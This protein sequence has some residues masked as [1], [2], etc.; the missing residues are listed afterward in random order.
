MGNGTPIGRV[1][2][3]GSAHGGAHHWMVQRFTAF[4]NLALMAWFGIS[5][6]L[7]PN[8]DYITFVDWLAQPVSAT[9]LSLLVVSLFWHAR[10][11]LQVV[12]EDYVQ[13]PSSK[14]AA[15]TLLNLISF[16]GAAFGIFCVARIALG[17]AA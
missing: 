15:L 6:I 3:L 17:G 8:Y 1:R 4:A 2:G 9:A 10:M 11:G 7:L 5:L 13:S 12:V 14:F 16:G